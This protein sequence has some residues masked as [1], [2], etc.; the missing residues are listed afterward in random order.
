MSLAAYYEDHPIS[1]ARV[2]AAAEARRGGGPLTAEDLFEFDQDHYG[3]LEAVD[4]LARR[5]AIGPGARVL[6]VCAGLG[7]PARFVAMRRACRVVALELH[8][9]RAA[10]A[11]CLTRRVGL[12]AAVKVVR[13]DASALPFAAGRF[14]AC[15]SQEA[16]LHVDDKPGV[17]AGCRRV[18]APG[19]RLA[20]TDWIARPRLGDLERRRL[21]D[22]MAAVT[23]QTLD[24]YRALLAQAGFGAVEAEDISDEWRPILR[25]R[26]AAYRELR[27]TYV[28]RLG[29]P[30]YRAYEELYT[31]FVGLVEAGKLGGGRF[32]AT[33]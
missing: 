3:G 23:L 6:D 24:G 12:E 17:L 33:R 18:L 29:E 27:G 22:W 30:R 19:G 20:F 32:T 5:A 9:S 1:E 4:T 31:F 25:S 28:P 7:G 15:I 26:L 8:Q 13:A 21:S 11:A 10:G 16:L 14:D 2:L